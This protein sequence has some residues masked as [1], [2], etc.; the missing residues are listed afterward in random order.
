MQLHQSESYKNMRQR[1]PAIYI[2]ANK[3]NGTLYTGVTSNLIK[4]VQEHKHEDIRGFT[5]K[6]GC[7]LLVYYELCDNM[8]SAI[9]REKKIKG[10]SK[11]KK[12]ALIESMNPNWH[13]LYDEIV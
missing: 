9:E 8:Y 1:N 4:R 5:Q 7:E 11:K 2:M 3:R 10:G 13:D 6:H 12:L